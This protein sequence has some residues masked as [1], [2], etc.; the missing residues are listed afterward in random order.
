MLSCG[1][2]YVCIGKKIVGTHIISYVCNFF[3]WIRHFH[4]LFV[5]NIR[6]LMFLILFLWVLGVLHSKY[7]TG[8]SDIS[9]NASLLGCENQWFIC[10]TNQLH[11]FVCSHMDPQPNQQTSKIKLFC[12]LFSA[13]EWEKSRDPCLNLLQQC[14]E[15]PESWIECLPG[16]KHM[17]CL[18]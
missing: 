5:D 15:D 11:Q 2:E 1:F 14:E 9:E 12:H 4:C 18:S 3:I 8:Q 16:Y 17:F 7:V 13:E 10:D 6:F